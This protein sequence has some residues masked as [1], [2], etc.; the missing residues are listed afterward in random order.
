MKG[1]KELY[2]Y[3]QEILLQMCSH[4]EGHHYLRIAKSDTHIKHYRT[5]YVSLEPLITRYFHHSMRGYTRRYYENAV[6]G[7]FRERRE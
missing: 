6:K 1:H 5:I 3:C 4:I 7:V 2:L